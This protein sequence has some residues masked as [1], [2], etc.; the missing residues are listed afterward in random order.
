M[1]H[2][3][4][5]RLDANWAAGL[6]GASLLLVL[7][8]IAASAYVRLG[9]AHVPAA[10]E[11]AIEVARS[12]RRSAGSLAAGGVATLAEIAREL[13]RDES[14]IRAAMRRD[15]DVPGEDDL[16]LELASTAASK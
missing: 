9:A 6:A 5:A 3:R 14:T 1:P 11:S 8:V 7:A 12:I 16:Q 2:L 13:N 4:A 15:A 10:S